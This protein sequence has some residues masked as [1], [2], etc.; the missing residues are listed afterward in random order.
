M[1][2]QERQ[3]QEEELKVKEAELLRGN[4]LLNNPTSFNVKR[5][6]DTRYFSN[7]LLKKKKKKWHF[8]LLTLLVCRLDLNSFGFC[9]LFCVG[10]MMMWCSRTK[11]AVKPKQ[12]SDS[13]MIPSGMISIGNSCTNT[14]SKPLC[15]N[16]SCLDTKELVDL[17]LVSKC[18]IR[19]WWIYC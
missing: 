9:V 19:R 16:R 4:P 10:G 2:L 17:Q 6:F 14:W 8:L 5:R 11:P 12:L 7:L 1:C 3:Q 15:Q 18:M 13:S